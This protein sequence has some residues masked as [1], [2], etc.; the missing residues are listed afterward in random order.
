MFSTVSVSPNSQPGPVIT[1]DDPR[2]TRA[3][4]MRDRRRHERTA[5][6][7]DVC[8]EGVL[9]RD[10]GTLSDISLGGCFILAD[11]NVCAGDLMRVDIQSPTGQW[12]FLWGEIVHHAEG[13]GIGVRFTGDDEL[14]RS[15]LSRLIQ[16]LRAKKEVVNALRVLASVTQRCL[17]FETYNALV[18]E[19]LHN[20]GDAAWTT[21]AEGELKAKLSAMVEPFTDA[22]QVWKAAAT[23]GLE[24]HELRAAVREQLIHKYGDMPVEAPDKLMMSD[25]VPVL[26]F[27]WSYG[28]AQLDSSS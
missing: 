14:E 4:R 11:G 3:S 24:G 19:T 8:W 22:A 27:L 26:T 12:V 18:I 9:G 2:P 10:K 7:L 23:D 15:Q 16:R 5:V 13:I 28:R 6:C 25:P 17:S 21:L 1:G 20:I